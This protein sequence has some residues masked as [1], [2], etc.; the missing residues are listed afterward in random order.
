MNIVLDGL[1]L[2]TSSDKEK[3]NLSGNYSIGMLI[4]LMIEK[5]IPYMECHKCGKWDY[6]KY[7]EPH[8]INPDKASDIKC[9]VAQ[10]FI[11]NYIN[12]TF[13]SIKDLEPEKKQAYL[14]TAFY[15]SQ[16]VQSAEIS[17]GTFI[18]QDHL[19]GWG[20]YAPALYGFTKDTLGYLNKAHSSMKHIEMFK[21]IKNVILVEGYSEEIF[22][23]NFSDMKVVNYEG[24]GRINYSKIEF[25]VND[26]KEKGYE[27][28]L[29]SDL[30]GS[31]ENQNIKRI[32][33]E[34]LIKEENVFQ[35]KHDFESAIPVKLFYM[36]LIDNKII[37][38]TLENFTMGID[39]SRG[40][41]KYIENKYSISIN[42]RIIAT[43]ISLFMHRYSRRKNLY[44][45]KKF[46]DTEIGKFWFFITRII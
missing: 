31:N 7:V 15:L 1:Y 44:D 43:E 27:V 40:I 33:R 13:E 9:G 42:K 18:S 17:I 29:Q 20:S 26:Y 45:D 23:Q 12:T 10:D 14:N 24:K 46:M 37:D 16:Y 22:V 35:F 11:T 6:C 21:S 39:L 28:Y 5:W 2:Y 8:R 32:I 38:D 25:L 41:V 36:I 4:E 19:E 3:M 34:S 30:D